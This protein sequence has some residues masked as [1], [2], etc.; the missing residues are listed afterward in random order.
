MEQILDFVTRFQ[1]QTA[2]G[3][4]VCKLIILL[5]FLWIIG[6]FVRIIIKWDI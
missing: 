6:L 3:A 5:A 2:A 4:D 1:F